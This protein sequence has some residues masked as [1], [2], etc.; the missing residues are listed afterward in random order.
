MKNKTFI[1]I[2]RFTYIIKG[3]I[4]MVLTIWQKLKRDLSEGYLSKQEKA[5]LEKL[6][7]DY[8][9]LVAENKLLKEGDPK[10]T[11]WNDHFPKASI[12]YWG[13]PIPGTNQ[14]YP[15]DVRNMIFSKS[16]LIEELIN[17]KSLN[18][19][20]N[21]E[22]ALKCLQF[23]HNNITYTTDST[24]G[25][26]EY[27]L[28]P[29]ET[30]QRK[31]G[32]CEDGAILLASLLVMCGV[33]TYRV[34]ICAGDV[35]GGGHAYVIYLREIDDKWVVLDWCYWYDS[36]KVKDRLEHKSM[37]KYLTI[38]FTF[39]NQFSWYH[40]DFKKDINANTTDRLK[41]NLQIKQRRVK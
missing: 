18:S 9:L 28:Y 8:E 27:W 2:L 15:L 33:P 37:D 41:K 36:S 24:L 22:K 29:S 6:K 23:V 32:D 11:Y 12:Q 21:D 17:K 35:E 20:S 5:D 40:P 26:S 10:A 38:W 13:R 30:W 25:V 3:F 1:N 14:K 7:A 16:V 34:K 31:L 4:K 39:N 19:G